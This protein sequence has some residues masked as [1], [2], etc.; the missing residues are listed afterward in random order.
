VVPKLAKKTLGQA[1]SALKK[2]HCKL[3]KVT[4]PRKAKG[5]LVV[6]SSSPGAGKKLAENA[7][8]NVKLGPKPKKG[9]K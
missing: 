3:G 2:A 9:K 4:K 1:K 5:A 8:V 6:K 7:K